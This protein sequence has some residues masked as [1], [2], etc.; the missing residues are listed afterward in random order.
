MNSPAIIYNVVIDCL[1]L[2]EN[3]TG[4]ADDDLDDAAADPGDN[5]GETIRA[6]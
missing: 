6:L 2:F 1:N 5:D 3:L 4:Q